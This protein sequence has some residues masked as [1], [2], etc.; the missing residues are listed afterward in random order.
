MIIRHFKKE[1]NSRRSKLMATV[2]LTQFFP[3]AKH[4]KKSL[5]R[6]FH[7]SPEKSARFPEHYARLESCFH[8]LEST[9]TFMHGRDQ[10]IIFHKIQKAVE[11]S[12]NRFDRFRS[13][14]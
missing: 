2:K 12:C 9:M 13:L 11:N 4:D 8:A 1:N 3:T 10:R 6:K 14:F 5:K 7:A